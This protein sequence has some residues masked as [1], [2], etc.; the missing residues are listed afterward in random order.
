MARPRVLIADDHPGVLERVSELLQRDYDIVA[1]VSDGLAAVDAALV[2]RPDI[3]IFDVSMPTLNGFQAAA[4]IADGGCTPR[5]V[6]LT[7]HEDP[8]FVEAARRAGARGYVAKRTMIAELLPAIR[9]VLD[10]Q[11]AFRVCPTIAANP[12]AGAEDGSSDRQP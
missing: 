12:A 3:A 2:L 1:V 5:V 4:R 10:G 8:G 6:F 11:E 9:L 7:V